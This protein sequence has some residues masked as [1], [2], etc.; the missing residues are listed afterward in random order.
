VTA[1]AEADAVLARTADVD[2]HLAAL[3]IRARALDFLGDRT[4][5]GGAW[6]A[7]AKQAAA[8][9]RTQAELRAVFQLGKQEFFDGRRPIRLREAA[10]LARNAGALVELAWAEETLA[11]ALTLQGDP[12]AALKVLDVAIPAPGNSGSISSATC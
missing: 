7:Q 1:L 12:A 8:A 11:I 9:G 2:T 4:A 6:T 5:A 10:E 3:D